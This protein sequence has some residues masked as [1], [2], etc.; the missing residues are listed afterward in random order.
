MLGFVV[1]LG[2]N[3]A[4][5]LPEPTGRAKGPTAPGTWSGSGTNGAVAAGGQGAVDAGIDILQAGG[6]AADAAAATL[7]ALSVTD[8]EF[9]CFGGEVPILVY[10][11]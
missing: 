4:M 3:V 1:V 6:N 2:G 10:D 8:S 9:F 11:A 7:F 5:A